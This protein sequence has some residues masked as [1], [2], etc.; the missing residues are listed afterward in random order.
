[1]SQSTLRPI[2]PGGLRVGIIMDGNGRWAQARGRPRVAGHRAGA[3]VARRIVEAAP[4]LGI[5]VLTL[6]AFSSDN[7]RRP[8]REVRSLMRLFRAYLR[9]EVRTCVERGVRLRILGR[10]DRLSASLLAAIRAAEAATSGGQK[11]LLR[12]ALDYSARDA[13]V[14]AAMRAC[15][16]ERL[17]RESFAE[18]LGAAMN[19]GEA[20]SDLDLLIRTGGE[21]RLSDFLLWESAYAELVF[22]P[23]MWPDFTPAELEAAVREYHRRER[24]FGRVPG[25]SGR[26]AWHE[27]CA[28]GGDR[29]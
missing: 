4:D 6:Y 12:V 10:R 29:E 2:D 14:E 25:E 20:S 27:V 22:S 1:M 28:T 26:E 11:L 9:T 16:R 19:L 8:T 24:R 23:R 21:Q 13:I 3:R 18:L 15:G 5:S 17:T 7:W